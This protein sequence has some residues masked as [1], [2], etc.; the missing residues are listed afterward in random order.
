MEDTLKLIL[1]KITNVQKDLTEVKTDVKEIKRVLNN[2]Q[3]QTADLTEFKTETKTSLQ[4]IEYKITRTDND[5]I[6]L[7]TKFKVIK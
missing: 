4:R 3:D 6:D 2:V 1:E 5:V 7:K